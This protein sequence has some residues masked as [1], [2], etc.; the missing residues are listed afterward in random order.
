MIEAFGYQGYMHPF[1][2]APTLANTK[3]F[4]FP[5]QED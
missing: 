1:P 5:D 4:R 3:A 2:Q